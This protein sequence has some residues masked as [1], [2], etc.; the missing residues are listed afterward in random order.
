MDLICAEKVRF[1]FFST[2]GE[3]QRF[4]KRTRHGPTSAGPAMW[5]TAT[6]TARTPERMALL[7]II[8][9]S[10]HAEVVAANDISC[11]IRSRKSRQS[12]PCQWDLPVRGSCLRASKLQTH[13]VL[14]SF[15]STKQLYRYTCWHLE[16]KTTREG[17]KMAC[18]VLRVPFH[19]GMWL[20]LL[21]SYF[22]PTSPDSLHSII[23]W[24]RTK[25]KRRMIF[26]FWL[27]VS[28]QLDVFFAALAPSV[29]SHFR[30]QR[31][32]CSCTLL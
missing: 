10:G 12:V 20:R 8:V 2:R 32:I 7:R 21:L 27:W 25:P 28:E 26:L 16:V 14:P 1:R 5:V 23:N 22:F 13:T 31:A 6:C 11:F 15:S 18:F 9:I 3:T 19:A 4:I 30:M 29:M 24:L 17:N